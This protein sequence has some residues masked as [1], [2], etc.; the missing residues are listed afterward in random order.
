MTNIPLMCDTVHMDTPMNTSEDELVFPPPTRYTYTAREAARLA[1][2]SV[3]TIMRWAEKNLI[4]RTHDGSGHAFFDPQ[5][6]YRFVQ[7]RPDIPTPKR[8]PS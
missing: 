4:T 1:G 8:R 7:R 6:I 3:R 5:E 2:R